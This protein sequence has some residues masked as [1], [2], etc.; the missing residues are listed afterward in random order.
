VSDRTVGVLW[1]RYLRVRVRAGA[2]IPCPLERR[3]VERQAKALRDRLVV[4]YSPLA[5]YVAGRI[6]ART[7]G[8][9]DREDVLSWGLY[10]LL[11]A[12]ETYDP[13]RPAKFETYAISKIRWSILDELRKAD[14]LPRSARLRMQRIERE[15]SDL[16]QRYGRAP[17]E[18]EVC[19]RLGVSVGEHRA[20]LE[21]VA[22]SKVASLEAGGEVPEGGLHDLVADRLAADPGRAAEG[23]EVRAI[24]K[25]AIG[26]LGEQERV[27]TTF[28]YYEGLTLREIGGILN[29]TEGRISQILRAAMIRLRNSLSEGPT[30]PEGAAKDL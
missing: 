15:R 20:F 23:A 7:V 28:Y 5:R 22:R 27:V 8:P 6:S 25:R 13:A 19:G 30:L 12:V 29:L 3:R 2:E 21:R 14:P 9:L 26:E 1:E 17:T 10:G 24:L 4:N 11:G 16:T 18:S